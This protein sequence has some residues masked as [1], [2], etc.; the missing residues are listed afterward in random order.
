MTAIDKRKMF[1]LVLID[2]TMDSG[3]FL[4]CESY[5]IIQLY[6]NNSLLFFSSLFSH[7]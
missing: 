1:L 5:L 6:L 7:S 3:E 4:L 2:N